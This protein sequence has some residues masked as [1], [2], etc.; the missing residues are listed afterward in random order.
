MLL[1]NCISLLLSANATIFILLLIFKYDFEMIEKKYRKRKK[2]NM[3][4]IH[5]YKIKR[6][7]I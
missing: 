5:F 1:S 6:F 7:T 3:Y 4:S 2:E